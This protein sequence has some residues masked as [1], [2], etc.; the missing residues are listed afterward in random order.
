MSS[1]SSIQQPRGVY[2]IQDLKKE[3]QVEKGML[4]FRNQVAKELQEMLTKN[5]NNQLENLVQFVS[6]SQSS[7]KG[8]LQDYY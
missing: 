4:S 3:N 1:E 2:S 8:L 7:P 5:L 6:A